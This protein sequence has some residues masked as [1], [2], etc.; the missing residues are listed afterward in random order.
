M[1]HTT[2]ASTIS[3]AN[4]P[5]AET[6]ERDDSRRAKMREKVSSAQDTVRDAM[7]GVRDSAYHAVDVGSRQ[8]QTF[9]SEFDSAVRRN[10]TLAIA[11]AVGLGVLLGMTLSSRR[12]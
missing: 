11:G 10:P 5:E 3:Q 4:H 12:S 2:T 8:A 1:A 9:Q 6:T 7:G